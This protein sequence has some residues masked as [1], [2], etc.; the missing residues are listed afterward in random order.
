MNGSFKANLLT[1]STSDF[2][3]NSPLYF[4]VWVDLCSRYSKSV[5]QADRKESYTVNGSHT[6]WTITLMKIFVL[7]HC[8][9]W[10]SIVVWMIED[11]QP[12]RH[13]VGRSN[14]YWKSIEWLTFVANRKRKPVKEIRREIPIV[15]N[16]ICY[17]PF[18]IVLSLNVHR[19][20][21]LQH[22]RKSSV[23]HIAY[24]EFRRNGEEKAKR[25]TLR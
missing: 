25:N 24:E 4:A 20:C 15:F 11:H 5:S 13:L 16:V 3:F 7:S 8:K 14:L 21:Q 22:K 19:H 1:N 17:F 12:E 6:N 18:E 23:L 2:I 9:L 10:H